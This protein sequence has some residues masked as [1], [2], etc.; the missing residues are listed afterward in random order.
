M[1]LVASQFEEDE[2]RPEEVEELEA[3]SGFTKEEIIKLYKRFKSLD[4]S[5]NG[6]INEEELL[7]IPEVAMNPMVERILGYF[8]FGPLAQRLN[9][10]TVT[11]INFTDFVKA[12]S[13]FNGRSTKEEKLEHVFKAFDLDG[14]GIISR[15]EFV[16]LIRTLVGKSMDQADIDDLVQYALSEV[17]HE[18]GLR[19]VDFVSILETSSDID[20]LAESRVRTE[21]S[22]EAFHRKRERELR[23]F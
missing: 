22:L 5:G 12:L 2:L 11:R 14:D 16:T 4:R 8:G 9:G 21:S 7:K 17:Q 15:E 19:F 3:M 23:K 1:G 13:L 20:K 6:T 10:K 18:N